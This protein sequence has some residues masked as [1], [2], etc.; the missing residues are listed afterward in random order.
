MDKTIWLAPVIFMVFLQCAKKQVPGRA[1]EPLEIHI[2]YGDE[3]SFGHLGNPQRQVNVLGNLVGNLENTS[4]TFTLN[5]AGP[6]PLTLGSDLRR[7]AKPGDFNVEIE[8]SNLQEGI[9]QIVI[10]AEGP[11][12]NRVVKKVKVRYTKAKVWPLPYSIDWSKAKDIQDVAQIVDGKWQ[13]GP[14]GVRTVEP[15][16]DR[17]IAF[18]DA[19]W[20]NYEVTTSV[21]FHDFTVPAK[22]PPTFNVSHAAIATK[23]PGHDYDS[24]QPNRKWFPVGATSEFRLTAGLDSCRWRIFDGEN[25]YKEDKALIRHIVLDKK[26]HMKHRVQ[27]LSEGSTLYQV[28][29]WEDGQPEP[30]NWDLEAKEPPGDLPGGSALLIAHNTDVTF[31]NVKVVPI[32]P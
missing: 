23:W 1:G 7:L 30:Q 18:G 29:L 5:E 9:N 6:Y 12:K 32:A 10:T 31:G 19:T 2:W 20:K 26:Y 27:T 17:V 14:N 24:L 16:Y 28:K 25:F 11:D 22:G 8:T 21:I 15:Y 13:L 4:L 3:Q